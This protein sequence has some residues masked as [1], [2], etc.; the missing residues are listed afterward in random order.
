MIT[1]FVEQNGNKLRKE[2][3]EIWKEE[4]TKKISLKEKNT[5]EKINN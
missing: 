2:G 1:S 4:K 3:K 5:F